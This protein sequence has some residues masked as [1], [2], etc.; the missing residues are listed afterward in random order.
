MA[1][2]GTH[3]HRRQNNRVFVEKT[4][5]A[6]DK[7]DPTA[8]V[9]TSRKRKVHPNSMAAKKWGMTTWNS[10]E[11]RKSAR[12]T[13]RGGPSAAPRAPPHPKLPF[14]PP[15]VRDKRETAQPGVPQEP[16]AAAV[17][18][19]PAARGEQ[20][21]TAGGGCQVPGWEPGGTAPPA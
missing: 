7:N 11:V 9:K 12:A 21:D 14:Q 4:F 17:Q 20:S 2:H 10:S 18:S 1:S 19:R 16:G 6:N 5:A 8:Y 13:Y 15:P 3:R